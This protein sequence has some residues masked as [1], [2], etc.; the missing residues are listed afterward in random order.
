[1]RKCDAVGGALILTGL[2][3]IAYSVGSGSYN[4]VQGA[5]ISNDSRQIVQRDE[6]YETAL[7]NVDYMGLGLFTSLVGTLC[8]KNDRTEE[9]D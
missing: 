8:F 9:R 3:F 4:A 1:M 2:G 6:Y 7:S 5:L